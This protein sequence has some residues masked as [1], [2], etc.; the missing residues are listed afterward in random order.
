MQLQNEEGYGKNVLAGFSV[1]EF[2][3]LGKSLVTCTQSLRPLGFDRSSSSLPTTAPPLPW[4]QIM[5]T[6]L[7]APP[8]LLVLWIGCASKC[9]R[10]TFHTHWPFYHNSPTDTQMLV[11][12]NKM[13][14][15]H[16]IESNFYLGC[17]RCSWGPSVPLILL[18]K[19][20]SN[21]STPNL[22]PNFRLNRMSAALLA[23]PCAGEVSIC[24]L[25]QL[26]VPERAVWQF[27]RAIGPLL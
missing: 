26:P 16:S 1:G 17:W 6:I 5:Q 7:L 24:G 14:V 25:H 27:L 20:G 13:G 2:I 8:N 4:G 21:C 10:L 22:I 23:L 12:V 11:Y 19:A 15:M 3:L 9:E 18:W